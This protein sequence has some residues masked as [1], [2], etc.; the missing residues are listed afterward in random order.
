MIALAQDA[1]FKE[2]NCCEDWAF[3]EG[4]DACFERSV[5]LGKYD[6]G[7]LDLVSIGVIEAVIH[8]SLRSSGCFL[9]RLKEGYR[10]SLLRSAVE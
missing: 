7:G 1:D 3:A 8:Y 4:K 2:V 10:G 6:I 9:I 5:M